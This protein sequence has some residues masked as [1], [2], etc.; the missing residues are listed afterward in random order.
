MPNV[1]LKN[2]GSNPTLFYPLSQTHN[3]ISGLSKLTYK[4]R[5]RD[6]L[7]LTNCLF[8]GESRFSNNKTKYIGETNSRAINIYQIEKLNLRETRY[9]LNLDCYPRSEWRNYI[10]EYNNFIMSWANKM[11]KYE[12]IE[13]P[14]TYKPKPKVIRTP[15]SIPYSY[16]DFARGWNNYNIIFS[17]GHYLSLKIYKK[18]YIIYGCK[19]EKQALKEA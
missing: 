7:D 11:K 4:P 12:D 10:E 1:D 6:N 18:N 19:D 16:A 17:S 9:L 2:I 5:F 3:I 14:D 13:V 15:D 8:K